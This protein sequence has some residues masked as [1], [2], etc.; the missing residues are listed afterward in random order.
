ML[1][2][3]P[4]IQ[5]KSEEKSDNMSPFAIFAI[6]LTLAYIIYYGVMISRDLTRKPGQ[7]TTDEEN[8]EV[9]NFEQTDKPVKVSSVGDGYQI[10]DRPAYQPEPPVGSV[11]TLDDDGEVALQGLDNVMSSEMARR[12]GESVEDME[13][14]DVDSQPE[15]D[16]DT[17]A[18]T[19]ESRHG[20]NI[21][22]NEDEQDNTRV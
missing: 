9:D 22:E 1:T 2:F 3:R 15:V 6:V 4:S 21:N 19:M 16:A 10:G 5:R 8:I 12:V 7:E 11:V 20:F 18:K 13:D 14:I 17:Y